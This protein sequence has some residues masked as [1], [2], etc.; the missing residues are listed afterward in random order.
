MSGSLR[1]TAIRRGYGQFAVLHI[2]HIDSTG[3]RVLGDDLAGQHGFD[4]VLQEP[5][6]GTGTIDRVITAVHDE[7]L[8]GIGE[9]QTQLTVRQT[10]L[11]VSSQQI[12]D[13][14]GL[15][16]LQGL[17][18][19]DLIQPVEELGDGTAAAAAFP[20]QPGRIR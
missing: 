7:V 12:N 16:L 6:E 1:G 14:L 15:L 4:A 17:V 19:Y 11:Q 9:P 3:F 5:L 20:L 8:G 2:R 10:L 13:L 18:E